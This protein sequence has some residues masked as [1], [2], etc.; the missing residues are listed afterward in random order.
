MLDLRGWLIAFDL[1]FTVSTTCLESQFS[2][3]WQ[4]V[5]LFLQRQIDEDVKHT[6]S[7]PESPRLVSVQPIC[8]YSRTLRILSIHG[9]FFSSGLASAALSIAFFF[10]T[11][12]YSS[13]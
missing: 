2:E 11:L 5:L 4:V 7:P 8:L 12:L 13:I 10:S 1:A 3:S 6:H 9:F